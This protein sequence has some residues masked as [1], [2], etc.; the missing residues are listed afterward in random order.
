MCGFTFSFQNIR[1]V[2][3]WVLICESV[4][5]SQDDHVWLTGLVKIQ[6]LAEPLFPKMSHRTCNAL[7]EPSPWQKEEEIPLNLKTNMGENTNSDMLDLGHRGSQSSTVTNRHVTASQNWVQN[8][9][10][11]LLWHSEAN[12]QWKVWC[13][14]FDRKR[15]YVS[16]LKISVY[17]V[18]YN[19]IICRQT[20]H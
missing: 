10:K 4:N 15:T 14:A 18:L 16:F 11:T 19:P 9:P 12:N 8:K 20:E 7:T 17:S 2:L 3:S 13:R 1:R 6:L 5:S